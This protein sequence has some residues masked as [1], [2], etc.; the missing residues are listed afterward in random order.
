MDTYKIP[1]VTALLLFPFV[2]FLITVPYMFYQYRKYG[3]IPFFRSLVIY[4]F[5]LYLMCAYFLVILPLPSIED[6]SKYTTPSMQLV[7]FSFVGDIIKESQFSLSE[8][9]TYLKLIFNPAVYQVFYNVLL[10]LPFGF[11][12]RYYFNFSLKKTLFSSFLLSLFFELTQLSG[13]YGIYPRSYRLFDVDDLMIN[14]VGGGVGCLLTPLISFLFPSKEKLD[15]ISYERGRQVSYLRRLLAFCC[16][17]ALLSCLSVLIQFLIPN[18]FVI[19]QL[20]FGL[21]FS[22]I[23]SVVVCFMVIPYFS[24]GSSFGNQLLKIRVETIDHT[25]IYLRHYVVRYGLLYFVFIPSFRYI[26]DVL[27]LDIL[28][29]FGWMRLDIALVFVMVCCY[30]WGHVF[31]SMVTRKRI[32]CYE[33]MSNTMLVSTI[34][35]EDNKNIK[36]SDK[37]K[38]V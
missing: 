26:L 4:S 13:L 20:S 27:Q 14:T 28:N 18:H 2:A 23:V 25:P 24:H 30:F 17:I 7:P 19:N 31:V 5:V 32:L 34:V 35:V 29:G 10:L 6:V 15:Q 21:P 38:E 37:K 1:I 12:L 22:Y 9:S 16:D 3:S 36:D 33:K 11:Y 8:P